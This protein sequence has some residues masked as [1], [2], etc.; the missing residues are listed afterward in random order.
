[1]T[2][3]RDELKRRFEQNDDEELLDIYVNHK[4]D[5]TDE[6]LSVIRNILV[7]RGLTDQIL[8]AMQLNT[9]VEG[10]TDFVSSTGR[11]AYL[12][13]YTEGEIHKWIMLR[14]IEWGD[15]P[16]F[17]A[18][19]I[20]PVLMLIFEWWIIV[21]GIVIAN[22]LWGLVRYKFVSVPLA[23]FGCLFVRLKWF[24]SP[25]MGLYFYLN[26][27][28]LNAILALSWPLVTLILLA[29]RFYP[30]E[31]GRLERMFLEKLGM[32]STKPE[33]V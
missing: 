22:L 9:Q 23:N 31:L 19:P 14:A 2:N 25:A 5:Y 6:S 24:T 10:T 15:W 8:L 17:I 3:S 21:L 1:M 11:T 18:Q 27:N 28:I 26:D 30:I 16:L 32:L 7:D 33:D 29:V 13:G 4:I 20:I 12:S